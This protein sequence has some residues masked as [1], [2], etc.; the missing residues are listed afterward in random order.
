MPDMATDF[1]TRYLVLQDHRM[2]RETIEIPAGT[3]EFQFSDRL[4]IAMDGSSLPDHCH[5]YD[6]LNVAVFVRPAEC[7]RCPT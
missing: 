6:G 4:S 2:Q 7:R 5:A 3:R 1:T